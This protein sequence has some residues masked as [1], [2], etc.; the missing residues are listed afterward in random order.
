MRKKSLAETNP[1][2]AAEIHPDS[3]IKATEVTVG[4]TQKPLWMCER[5]HI[6]RAKVANRTHGNGCPY[7]SG[8]KVLPGFND[9]A[10]V[11]PKLAEEVSPN[12][13]VKA[14]EVTPGS[15]KRLLWRCGKGHEWATTVNC[16]SKGADCP[17]CTGKKILPGFNDLATVNPKLA[18]EVSPN[19][20]FKAEELTRCS[21]RRIPWVCKDGHEW[22]ATVDNRTRGNG[23]P[24]C[25]GRK[26][27]IDET[28]LKTVNPKLAREVSP[29]SKIKS[30]EVTAFSNKKLLWIC[31]KD[32]EWIATVNSRSQ[33]SGCPYCSSR[34]VL[35]GF[36]DLAT[37]NT[38]LAKQVSPN[39]KIEATEVTLTSGKRLLWRCSR[40]HEWGATVAHRSNSCGCPYCS[41][42]KIL[43]GFNDLDTVNTKLAKEVSPNSKIKAT[44]VTAGSNKKLLW[45]CAKEHEW[46]ATVSDRIRGRGCPYCSNKKILTEFNDL[47][48]VNPK[49]ARE[50]S[51]N[52]KIKATEVT[53]ISGE[54]LLWIC[55][56]GH[57]WKTT[58][59]DRIRGRGC[60][61]C[62]NRRVLRGFNDLATTNPELAKEVSPNSKVKAEGV[63]VG[64]TKKLLWRCSKGHEW[65]ATVNSRSQGRGCP[66]CSNN[67]LLPGFNDLATTNPELAK[68]VSPNSKVK[69]EGVTVG[70][71]KK[72]LWRCSKGHEWIATVNSRSS[73]NSGCP[74]CAGSQAERDLAEL[75]KSL[76]PEH[77]KILRNDRKVIKPYELD[78]LIPDLNLAFEFNGTYWHSDEVVRANKPSFPSSKAF[79]DFKKT[80]CAKQGIKLFFV[81]EKPWTEN[82]EKEV[83]R[84][85]KIVRAAL[86]KAA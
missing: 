53:A 61:Y 30:T 44:E 73:K 25:S 85:E 58:V 24:Y 31:S 38:E 48:T 43:A 27:L 64:T 56:K 49:L 69:A 7:C 55:S 45:R 3:D 8:N 12:S 76:L 28:D 82:R 66:Y 70:T 72:L 2:L 84:V 16:R 79:D 77:M 63:T 74:Q 81:R 62:S 21:N 15:G 11:N 86:K 59:A 83:K 42:K 14:T 57:E 52:S 13:K 33:G 37:V 60:P 68:E 47:K 26:A 41:N 35:R 1:E 18:S 9:L 39:S 23:C 34:R 40:G 36:N 50:V 80:E 46:K 6:W 29:N 78:I 65:I 51:P 5:G 17:Y 19:S 20:P 22:I 32:H 75:V 10:T 71:T 4:S 67:K 54:K